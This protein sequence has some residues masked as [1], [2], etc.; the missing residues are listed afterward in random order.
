MQQSPLQVKKKPLDGLF[1]ALAVLFF[2]GGFYL[3]DSMFLAAEAWYVRFGV[4]L[5]ALLLAAG[6]LWLTGYR[7]KILSLFKGARIEWRKLHWP[8]KDEAVKATL[9]V[10]AIVAVFA[11][12]LSIIDWFLAL[13]I[14]GIM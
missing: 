13:I 4:V 11:I 5:V 8:T 10:L 3:I 6:C 2:L 7:S 1:T 9:M 12:F 14:R